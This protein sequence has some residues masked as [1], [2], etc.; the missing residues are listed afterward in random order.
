MIGLIFC[1]KIQNTNVFIDWGA[2]RIEMVSAVFDFQNSFSHHSVY[3]TLTLFWLFAT[4]H[5]PPE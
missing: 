5:Q 3:L 4:I 1:F 2:R